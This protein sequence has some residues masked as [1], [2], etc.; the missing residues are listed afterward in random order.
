MIKR[1]GKAKKN[2]QGAILIVVVLILALAMIFIAT[3]MML[4][5][6]TR[7]RL[8]E[9]TMSSQ[10]RL[11]VTSAAE[12]FLEALQTQE[13]TDKQIDDMLSET[14]TRHTNNDDKIKMVVPGVPGMSE[15]DGNCTYLDLYFYDT[16]DKNT[17]YADFT[18]V[19]GDQVENVRIILKVQNGSTHI[20]GRFKN[21][22]D[23]AGAVDKEQLRFDRGVGMTSPAARTA[24]VTDNTIL[25][26]ASAFEESSSSKVYSD[27]VY[28]P[29]AVA[30][31]GGGNTFYGSN[32]FLDGAYMT[33]KDSGVN[34]MGDFYFIGS[35][36]DISFK[37][38]SA[39]LWKTDSNWGTNINFYFDGRTI[40]DRDEDSYNDDAGYVDY[41]LNKHSCYFVGKG[42]SVKGTNQNQNS[43]PTAKEYTINNAGSSLS[44]TAATN[45]AIYKQY[46]YN[47]SNP[48]Y[49]KFPTDT[50]TEV[51]NSIDLYGSTTVLSEAKTFDYDNYTSE[52]EL[53]EAGKEIPAGTEII[54]YPLT[55]TYPA[56]RMITKNGSKI[57]DPDKTIE[58][59]SLSTYDANDDRI[60]D[61]DKGGAYYF[62]PGKTVINKSS[63]D[64]SKR[65][66]V[67]AIDGSKTTV[68]YFA[69]GT[70]NFN[71]CCFAIYNASDGMKPVIM[72]LED[73]A[74]FVL[75]DKQWADDLKGMCT[76]G[77]LSLDRGFTKADAL[78]Q[79]I[80][81]HDFTF[82]DTEWEQ[83]N[84]DKVT[85]SSYYDGVAR[86]N[87]YIYGTGNNTINFGCKSIVEAYIGLYA[88]EG[89]T[90]GFGTAGDGA[91]CNIYGRLE[92]RRLANGTAD[93]HLMPYCPAPA[94]SSSDPDLRPAV[95]KYKVAR[96][97]YYPADM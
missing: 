17:V 77:F 93:H 13:I 67:I 9:N 30:K 15:D 21:Q 97:I 39:N 88:D 42:G 82:E 31:W 74:N 50:R 51:F 85:Y 35:S 10:A 89:S 60:I 23:I 69:S 84:G 32:I 75:S 64:M 53:Y 37:V 26:R 40:Q 58:V 16:S 87:F 14:P 52:G 70:Y 3:A 48:N 18:T 61:L 12:V 66:Y 44:G 83:A 2:K 11:T 92:G 46:N 4:T 5:Q 78:G 86:P 90:A 6:A 34:F 81:Y 65:P 96:V 62:K 33:T 94:D 19:I 55:T 68:L 29:G 45:M 57:I 73:G 7:N 72:V 63:D 54:T 27:V 20:G 47:P 22:I 56:Y 76:S 1:L 8:Y 71:M 49:D 80:Q 79:Y 38:T 25:L 36:D 91:M 28:A 43:S 41:L 95:T 59:G 24:G